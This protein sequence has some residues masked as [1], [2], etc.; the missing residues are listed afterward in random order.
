MRQLIDDKAPPTLLRKK[1]VEE[2]MLEFRHSALL[3]VA[4]GE[5]TLDEVVRVMPAEYLE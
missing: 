4:R 1:A 5:T 3:K 2:G